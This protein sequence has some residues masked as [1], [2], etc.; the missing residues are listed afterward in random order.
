MRFVL[1]AVSLIVMVPAG[2]AGQ[3]P[4]AAPWQGEN[5]QYFPKDIA[6]PQ[7]VQRMREFS[8]AL[9][10]RCQH[11]HSGGDG[12]SFDGVVFASDDKAAKVKARAMLR[13]VDQIN[14]TLLAAVP[15]RAEPRVSVD[16]AT[17]HRGSALPKSLQT[18]LFETVSQEGAAAAVAKYRALRRDTLINGKFNFGEWEINELARRLSEAG[19]TSAAITILEMNGEFHP[20]SAEIEF[21]LG[22]LHRGR[23]EMASAV[24]R[25]RAALEK[26]PR[27]QAAKR[28]LSELTRQ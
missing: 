1:Y 19:N 24:S 18:T 13:M 28:W 27:H 6:R 7:L 10:V 4:A 11:C 15:S 2:A 25:Y 17:C 12:V 21:T 20:K 5:L 3:A 14:G 23:G 26:N 9:D 8:F 22:E 16:C